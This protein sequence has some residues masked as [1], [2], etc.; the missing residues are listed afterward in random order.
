MKSSGD[1]GQTPARVIKTG[2]LRRERGGSGPKPS[3]PRGPSF[4]EAVALNK[5]IMECSSGEAVLA[6]TASHLADLDAV[7]VSTAFNMLS[8]LSPGRD[9]SADPRFEQLLAAAEARMDKMGAQALSNVL[10]AC[11][12]LRNVSLSEQWL[13]KYWR[14]SD[15]AL[16]QFKPQNFSNTLYA[17]SQLDLTLPVDWLQ[18]YWRASAAVLVHFKPQELSNTLYA[19]DQLGLTPSDEWLHQYWRASADALTQFNAQDYSNTLYACGRLGLKPPDDWL[20]KYWRESADALTQFNAQDYSNT[21]YACGQ[22]GLMPPVD[23]LQKYWRES[24][25]V[26]A[27]FKPQELSNTLYACGQLG[28][29]PPVNWRQHYWWASA[30][31]LVQFNAQALSNTLYACG[32]LGLTPPVNWLQQYWQASSASL[33]HFKP[34]ELSNTLYASTVLQLWDSSSLPQMWERLL[35]VLAFPAS[36]G[37]FEHLRQMYQVH[38]AATVER[39]GL[40]TT[41]SL[42]LLDAARASFRELAMTASVSALQQSVSKCLTAMG[43]AHTDEHWCERS[44]RTIDIAIVADGQRIAVEADGPTHFLLNGQPDGATR[45][46]DRCL[47]A[48]G[49]RVVVVPF[50]KWI[51]L[52]TQPKRKAFLTQL[53]A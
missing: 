24:A 49:W 28:L 7:N 33:V 35:C 14:A 17:C 51:K 37:S 46:R 40:L 3:R 8:K 29:M 20:Q 47:A 16:A 43:I 53:L 44:E 36:A 19:C 45:L 22:Q 42:A 2:E 4:R 23:W 21:L 48:H 1:G 13:K 30:A 39:P 50:S 41:P 11:S 10:H 25:A 27:Q 38:L 9:F 15:A 32:Q 6:L 26:L 12:K 34:Q 52:S 31:V 18:Q 5:Q